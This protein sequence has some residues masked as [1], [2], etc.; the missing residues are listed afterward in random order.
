MNN[1]E[2]VGNHRCRRKLLAKWAKKISA[3]V[4][5]VDNCAW[6]FSLTH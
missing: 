6:I 3:A 4:N 2:V 5:G 1:E